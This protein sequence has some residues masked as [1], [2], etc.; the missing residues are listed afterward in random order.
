[1]EQMTTCLID[2][3]T[4]ISGKE[5]SSLTA[6]ADCKILE[7]EAR[8]ICWKSPVPQ[9]ESSCKT[10]LAILEACFEMRLGGHIH[11]DQIE[12]GNAA[13]IIKMIALLT[14]ASLDEKAPIKYYDAL[15]DMSDEHV[16]H[17]ESLRELAASLLTPEMGAESPD[18]QSPA[19][20]SAHSH[21]SHSDPLSMSMSMSMPGRPQTPQTPTSRVG[22]MR[23]PS[24]CMVRTPH[25]HRL[26]RTPHQHRLLHTPI[27]SRKA[28]K[29]ALE[30]VNTENDDLREEL[31]EL[32]EELKERSAQVAALTIKAERADRFE[33]EL[34][35]ARTELDE[36]R[37][38]R[39][40]FD[41]MKRQLEH[42][43]EEL[44]Q[45]RVVERQLSDALE[46]RDRMQEE[47]AV[48]AKKLECQE[49]S[50][51]RRIS[52][53]QKDRTRV[54]ELE[55]ELSAW[56]NAAEN[57]E[58]QVKSL[59]AELAV[60]QKQVS[61]EAMTKQ[62][63]AAE[64]EADNAR[65]R[66][67]LNE[68]RAEVSSMSQERDRLLQMSQE[69]EVKEYEMKQAIS[70][71]Q[72]SCE[73]YKSA[74][75]QHQMKAVSSTGR[76]R[77]LEDQVE[78]LTSDNA[79]KSDEMHALSQ[80][81]AATRAQL[82]DLQ[83]EQSRMRARVSA[84]ERENAQLRSQLKAQQDSTSQNSQAVEEAQAQ[85]FHLKQ[86]LADAQEELARKKKQ[87]TLLLRDYNRLIERLKH[88]TQ[89]EVRKTEMLKQA[90]RNASPATTPVAQVSTPK[91]SMNMRR[92]LAA[93]HQPSPLQAQQSRPPQQQEA[94]MPG[95]RHH[96]QA[97]AEQTQ[98]KDYYKP[99][100]DSRIEELKRRNAALPPHLRSSNF[101][102]TTNFINAA[103]ATK[104][105]ELDAPE[106]KLDTRRKA[107]GK[108]TTNIPPFA[109]A[110]GSP[111][112]AHCE[113]I[114]PCVRCR[115]RQCSGK[116]SR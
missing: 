94:R 45:L 109:T 13:E 71:L 99:T 113:H 108:A 10:V 70:E 59:K 66:T 76:V 1:M 23:P 22:S 62:S 16:Q 7:E 28:A 32:Q 27:S 49:S 14:L 58:A 115:R 6:L 85:V 64:L 50:S 48:L 97:W 83:S 35:D 82:E 20:P 112:G 15:Q 4:K 79:A 33:A 63:D 42:A 47:K 75:S 12:Q 69:F 68:L 9:R 84:A 60:V 25:Q 30:R 110:I 103:P 11:T 107:W 29:R 93:Q 2:W 92:E 105:A 96:R 56:R 102:E 31:H 3:L 101:L 67:S 78:A 89:V 80:R 5:I 21:A 77:E 88:E 36:L 73:Q 114:S 40:R 8:T 51:R 43:N 98:S 100:D 54:S 19:S 81:L 95:P 38:V 37:D 86:Q 24:R 26:L 72:E 41:R 39:G 17:L 57:A 65:L 44:D 18:Q 104:K 52:E 34:E 46:A 90:S 74:C 116:Q 55:G 61:Q 111:R 53:L 91:S 87:N 106:P